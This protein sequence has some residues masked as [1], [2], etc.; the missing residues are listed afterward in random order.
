MNFDNDMASVTGQLN[1]NEFERFF[2]LIPDLAC[3][4][5]TDGYFKKLNPAWE[6]TLGYSIQELLS[7]PFLDFVHPEDVAPTFREIEKQGSGAST[8][9][10][11][12]RYRGKDGTYRLLE[13]KTT[14][15]VDTTILFAVARDIT[16]RRRADL[17]Q[18]EEALLANQEQL[19]SLA[20]ELSL[21]E[22]RERRRIATELHDEIGQNLALAKIKIDD[23][24]KTRLSANCAR[25]MKELTEIMERSIQEVRSLTFQISPPLLYEV[26]FE[27]AVEWLAE[28]FQEKHNLRV[29]ISNDQLPKQLG[30]ELGST[31]YHVV[32]EL[33]VNVVKHAQAKHIS[34]SLSRERDRMKIVVTD[35]GK[36][37]QLSSPAE[38]RKLSGFGLFNIRQRIQHLGGALDLESRIGIGTKVTIK[39]PLSGPEAQLG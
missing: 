26:S 3:I 37:F 23:L 13:W 1:Q 29:T 16:Q 24:S 19:R 30:E 28:Q 4:A 11:V 32:R 35:N 31:L 34:I 33:L 9:N 2:S 22:E 6:E 7:R 20:I 39:V 25:S 14:P 38:E 5:S 18:A 17:V 36:G 10:F 12:N 15:V 21:V 27:A 8:I